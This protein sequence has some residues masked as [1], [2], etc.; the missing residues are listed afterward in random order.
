M[1]PCPSRPMAPHCPVASSRAHQGGNLVRKSR[2]TAALAVV[3]SLS[4]S[5]AA[6]GWS[7]N[8]DAQ[9]AKSGPTSVTVGWKQPIYSYNDNSS[10]GNNVTNANI[11]YMTNGQFYYYDAKSQLKADTSFGTY[12]KTSDNP[13][14]VKYTVSKDAKWSDGTPYDA[15]DLLFT[16]AANSSNV[17]NVSGD[18]VKRDKATGAAKPTGNQVYFDS[19]GATPGQSLA[20]VKAT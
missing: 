11:R 20:L 15:A 9:Q 6:C 7:S 16:W 4:L 3:A 1:S 18:K 13:L 17:N 12:E 5:L 19:A 2:V 14:T 10:T 8:K